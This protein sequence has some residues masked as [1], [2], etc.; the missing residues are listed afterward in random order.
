MQ[1][2]F[3]LLMKTGLLLVCSAHANA[4]VLHCLNQK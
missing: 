4:V 3:N 1:F 2:H